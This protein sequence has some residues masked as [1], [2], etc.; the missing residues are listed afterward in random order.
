[1]HFCQ[2]SSRSDLKRGAL[3]LFEEV[4][5]PRKR[6]RRR[7]TTTTTATMDRDMK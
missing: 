2:I 1:M 6:K 4:V 5:A 3:G 7:T